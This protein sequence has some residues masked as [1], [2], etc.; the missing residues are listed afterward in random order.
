MK[1]RR[2]TQIEL[3]RPPRRGAIMVFAIIALLVTTMIGASLLRTAIASTRQIQREQQQIQATWLADAGCQRALAMSRKDPKYVGE[4]WDV[5][6]EQLQSPS[7]AM[8]TISIETG[9]TP[10]TERTVTAI[11]EYPKASSQA[12]RVTKKITIP[13]AKPTNSN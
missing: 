3:R 10:N 4:S 1:I 7:G 9:S 11:A 6:P 5:S 13:I 2:S 12:I 8:V